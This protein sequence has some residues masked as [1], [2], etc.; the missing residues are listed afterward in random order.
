[1]RKSEL[2][3]LTMVLLVAI[4]LAPQLSIRLHAQEKWPTQPAVHRRLKVGDVAPDFTL[5]GFDGKELKK[6]SLRDYRGKKN[7]ALAF[8]VYAFTDD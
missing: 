6:T 3:R 5:F 7:V 8:Y 1:M 2:A 4:V